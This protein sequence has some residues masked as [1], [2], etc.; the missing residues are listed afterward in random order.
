MEPIEPLI[1]AVVASCFL[2]GSIFYMM[3][4]YGEKRG[5]A[6]RLLG[7]AGT[8]WFLIILFKLIGNMANLPWLAG[9]ARSAIAL[10]LTIYLWG[11]IVLAGTLKRSLRKT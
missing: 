2:F 5:L 10:T 8:M 6:W 3:V 11:I 7:T 9:T 1:D 4:A